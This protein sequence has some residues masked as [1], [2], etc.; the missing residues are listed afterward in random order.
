[1]KQQRL[2][3]N[4]WKEK[5]IEAFIYFWW[6]AKNQELKKYIFE[7]YNWEIFKSIKETS[8]DWSINWQ[9]QFYSKSDWW[10]NYTGKEDLFY[11]IKKWFWSLNNNYNKELEKNIFQVPDLYITEIKRKSTITNRIIRDTKIVIELK[12]IYKN[13]C[14]ICW[15]TIK[16]NKW[17]YSEWHHIKPLW[18]DHNW[19]DIKENII[20]LCPNHHAEF[21]YWVIAIKPNTNEIISE[22]YDIENLKLDLKHH[23]NKEF[24]DYHF[25]NIYQKNY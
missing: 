9:L 15:K 7:K 4:W 13:C 14:Q 18:K 8:L 5:L 17:D 6:K 19:P 16:T 12:K 21:D 11:K 24:L 10:K 25:E 22:V 1:M 2:P 20:I 23:I 3:K